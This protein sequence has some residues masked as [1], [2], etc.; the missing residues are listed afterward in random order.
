MMTL[1]RCAKLFDALT[2]G[3]REALG[4]GQQHRK[5]G[6]RWSAQRSGQGCSNP[7]GQA[8]EPMQEL[9]ETTPF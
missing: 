6:A 4:D 7:I 8:V 2:A 1:Y 3:K 9:V 5:G